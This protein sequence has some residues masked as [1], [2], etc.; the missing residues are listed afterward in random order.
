[1]NRLDVVKLVV[2]L[3]D[4]DLDVDLVGVDLAI[5]LCG[6]PLSVLF[7]FIVE[8][9][10]DRVDVEFDVG[11][12]DYRTGL[13]KNILRLDHV[14]SNSRRRARNYCFSLSL[15]CRCHSCAEFPIP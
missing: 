5:S 15:A 8:L 14:F 9:I 13:Y 7:S 4:L 6:G 3:V 2:D 1:M 12:V 10:V 11:L